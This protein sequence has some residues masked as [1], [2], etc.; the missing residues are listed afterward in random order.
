MKVFLTD[1]KSELSLVKDTVDISEPNRTLIFGLS[2]KKHF[3][4][5]SFESFC[6]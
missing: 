3:C 2:G 4:F 5:A 6:Y 1:K